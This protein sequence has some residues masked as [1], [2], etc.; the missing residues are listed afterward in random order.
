VHRDI[1]HQ[2]LAPFGVTPN[3]MISIDD[4]WSSL[5]FKIVE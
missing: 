4:V 5:R 3:Q 1:V 2:T